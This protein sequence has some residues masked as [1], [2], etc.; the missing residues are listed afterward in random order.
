MK[1]RKRLRLQEY[2]YTRVGAYFITVCARDRKEIFWNQDNQHVGAPLVC[3]RNDR[4]GNYINYE[5][6]INKHTDV[7]GTVHSINPI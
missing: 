3:A 6:V 5:Y 7:T 2:D 4:N 1:Q